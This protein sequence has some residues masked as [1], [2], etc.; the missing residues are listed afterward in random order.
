LFGGTLLL[1]VAAH[2]T[3]PVR[4]RVRASLEGEMRREVRDPP[5]INA[6]QEVRLE[7]RAEAGDYRGDLK[8]AS[9]PP[10]DPP[11]D[12]PASEEGRQT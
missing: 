7:W 9:D 6:G 12:P 4:L 2:V 3:W 11:P 10:P 1:G 8:P 5:P